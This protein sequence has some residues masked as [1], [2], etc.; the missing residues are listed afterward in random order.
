MYTTGNS[1]RNNTLGRVG[2]YQVLT[3]D[4]GY[5]ADWGPNLTAL[6]IDYLN[7][8]NE[9][10][11]VV[12]YLGNQIGYDKFGRMQVGAKATYAI[13]PD[14]SISALG[15]AI[16]TATKVDRNATPVA[17]AGLV[18]VFNGP[19]ARDD[20]RYLGTEVNLLLT[21][22]FAPGLT[23]DNQFGYLFPGKAWDSLTDPGFARN[24]KEP[25]MLTSRVRF[26]F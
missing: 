15:D 25:F 11:G 8:H 12:G 1:R 26:T 18:P 20:S 10:A 5:L 7:A 4:T 23:W 3:T 16:W 17:G 24:V 6:G 21:W 14:L 9:A 13:T 19:Q 22:R 2:Y